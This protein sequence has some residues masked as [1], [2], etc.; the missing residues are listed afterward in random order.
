MLSEIIQKSIIQIFCLEW[1]TALKTLEQAVVQ[2][3]LCVCVQCF[4][5]LGV[6]NSVRVLA[7]VYVR[8]YIRPTYRN[9]LNACIMHKWMCLHWFLHHTY[10]ITHTFYFGTKPVFVHAGLNELVQRLRRVGHLWAQPPNE[11]VEGLRRVGH[12]YAQSPEG[13]SSHPAAQNW[14][15]ADSTSTSQKCSL[16][17][18]RVVLGDLGHNINVPTSWCGRQESEQEE[19]NLGS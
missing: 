12:L 19:A 15:I 14:K 16:H 17:K 5:L 18:T 10:K 11:L 13:I 1:F 7:C 9:D 8:M 2:Y 4:C 6:C 3:V